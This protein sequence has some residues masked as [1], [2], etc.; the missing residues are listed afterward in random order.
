MATNLPTNLIL[1]K[2]KLTTTSA[3]IPMVQITFPDETIVRFC[4]N[5]ENLTF[6]GE[7]WVAF[8]FEID[9]L[10]G[11]NQG[12]IPSV[13]LRISNANRLLQQYIE[14]FNGGV[15]A[16]VR[17]IVVNSAYLDDS[18]NIALEMSFDVLSSE[19]SSQWIS[20]TLGAPNPLRKRYPLY[21]AIANHCNWKFK[22]RE[23]NYVGPDTTC[24]R[25]LTA[26]RQKLNS[27]RYGGRFGLNGRIRLA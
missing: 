19:C 27:K 4:Q 18:D 1:E 22:S 7:T 23:C 14:Q 24:E 10:T 16:I 20:L 13:K 25:T 11:N 5:T 9:A 12:E 17:L 26:C 8:P 3:W 2:N 21:R 15:N 6:E